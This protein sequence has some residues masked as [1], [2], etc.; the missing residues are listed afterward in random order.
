MSII[1]TV[2]YFLFDVLKCILYIIAL[3][4]LGVL[5]ILGDIIY[6]PLYYIVK[7]RRRVVRKNLISSYPDKS[8]EEIVDLEKKFY[9]HF[10]NYMMETLKLISISDKEMKKRFVYKNLG[11]LENIVSD[12]KPVFLMMGHY[13]NWEWV[14]SLTVQ[15]PKSIFMA[16]IYSP[17][18][19]EAADRFMYKLRA[20]FHSLGIARNQTLREILRLKAEGKQLMVGFIADQRPSRKNLHLWT[21]FLNHDTPCL[22]GTEKIARKIDANVLFLDVKC[23]KRGYYEGKFKVISL[24]S[25]NTP[26]LYITTKYMQELET[27]INFAPQYWLWSHDRWKY[28]KE[29]LKQ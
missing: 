20:R 19:N 18:K 6:Y 7:Y 15:V 29:D 16:Q 25:K 26:E 10:C 12:G 9:H 3:L 1:K 2:N 11:E 13:G 17:L 23:T 21:D 8:L 14:T 28:N 27:T 5:Y 24:D 4:P 22:I